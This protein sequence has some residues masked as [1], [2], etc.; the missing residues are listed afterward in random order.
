MSYASSMGSRVGIVYDANDEDW[1]CEIGNDETFP[2]ADSQA[3]PSW[4]A[5]PLPP[6]GLPPVNQRRAPVNPSHEPLAQSPDR[7]K[8]SE[9]VMKKYDM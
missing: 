6:F 9:S 7:D 2:A 8:I 3:Y 5:V 1:D 4:S